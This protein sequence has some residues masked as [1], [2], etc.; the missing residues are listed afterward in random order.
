M[1]Q[2]KRIEK[3]KYFCVK[4]AAYSVIHFHLHRLA[5]IATSNKNI[6]F[7][8]NVNTKG[9]VLKKF[10]G[11][12]FHRSGF[13]SKRH[14]IK[15]LFHQMGG[16]S[17]NA[18]LFLIFKTLSRISVALLHPKLLMIQLTVLKTR[19]NCAFDE[20]AIQWKAASMKSRFDEKPLRW[21]AASMKSR[22]D[23]KPLRW[24]A[25][26]PKVWWS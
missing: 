2:K 1:R 6:F 21:K 16:I 22:F 3:K 26:P 23:E 5:C 11:A 25:A 18:Q 10:G 13:S 8:E 7:D 19:W 20:K 12:A 4:K 17:S 24:K 14:F 15:W 9:F